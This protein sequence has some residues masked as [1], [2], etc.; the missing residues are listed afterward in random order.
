MSSEKCKARVGSDCE[1]K[2]IQFLEDSIAHVRVHC[3]ALTSNESAIRHFREIT[4]PLY[5]IRQSGILFR[6]P[7]TA[8]FLQPDQRDQ[9][10]AL[11]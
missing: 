8:G 11:T 7:L 3:V 5:D 4:K 10:T 1:L 2:T 9:D 6:A